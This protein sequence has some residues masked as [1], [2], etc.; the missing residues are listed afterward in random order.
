[1][2]FYENSEI[3][4]TNVTEDYNGIKTRGTPF[5]IN[6]SLETLS[7]TIEF[8]NKNGQIVKLTMLILIET[9]ANINIGDE[10]KITKRFNN[11]I[12]DNNVYEV[13]RIDKPEGI[14][15]NHL[16]VYI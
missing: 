8:A 3:Q 13:K 4:I 9:N 12:T 5:K 10:I 7:E 15:F 1:M 2:S 11:F 14:S 6:C 16:E